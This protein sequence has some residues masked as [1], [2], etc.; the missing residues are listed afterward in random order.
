[1]LTL[2]IKFIHQIVVCRE[3]VTVRVG[4]WVSG[5]CMCVLSH[6]RLTSVP[7]HNMCLRV[8][9]LLEPEVMPVTITISN[10]VCQVDMG[11]KI[12]LMDVALRGHNTEFVP[13]KQAVLTLRRKG[14]YPSTARISASGATTVMG[15]KS[16]YGAWKSM[17]KHVR[18]VQKLGYSVRFSKFRITNVCGTVDLN[19]RL[20]LG[21]LAQTVSEEYRPRYEPEISACLQLKV[22]DVTF[23]VH[24]T[25][26]VIATGAK[27]SQQM[28][29]AA[30]VL[31]RILCC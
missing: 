2:Y 10:V 23:Q 4:G 14:K 9:T 8:Q 26:R 3:C 12:D 7:S 13:S 18:H 11:C 31:E 24:Q 1:M 15:S 6:T 25:G 28:H 27:S 17:R 5:R 30:A 21:E 16:E 29:N 20:N 19:Q 22:Q